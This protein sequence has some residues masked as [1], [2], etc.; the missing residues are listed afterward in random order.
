ML[1]LDYDADRR[2]VTPLDKGDMAGDLRAERAEQDQHRLRETRLTHCHAPPPRY[3]FP[4]ARVTR[5]QE[6][7]FCARQGHGA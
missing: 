7:R 3:D 1:I 5:R 6:Q 2:A 4:P